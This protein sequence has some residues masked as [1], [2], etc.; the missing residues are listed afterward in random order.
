MCQLKCVLP[1]KLADIHIRKVQP[2]D[3]PCDQDEVGK[4]AN[5]GENKDYIG[6]KGRGN[7]VA[8]NSRPRNALG[9]F[10]I[11]P[12]LHQIAFQGDALKISCK[13]ELPNLHK[14]IFSDN[15]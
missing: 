8:T 5:G 7:A 2:E 10:E 15:I 1:I 13:A 3:M 9:M 14:V 12:S 6:T 11:L 4:I